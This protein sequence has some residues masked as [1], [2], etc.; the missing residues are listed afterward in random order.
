MLT[1]SPCCLPLQLDYFGWMPNAPLGL[2]RPP[3]SSKGYCSERSLLDSLPD[4]HA[5]V[6]GLATIYL[7]SKKPT[8]FVWKHKLVT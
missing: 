1:C 4:V 3:P 5:T 8:D 7:L 6:H 2:Q